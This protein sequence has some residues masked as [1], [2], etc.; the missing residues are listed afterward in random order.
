MLVFLPSIFCVA[1]G[2]SWAMTTYKQ[3]KCLCMHSKQDDSR[4]CQKYWTHAA[5]ASYNADTCESCFQTPC[6]CF[7][8]QD[9]QQ[10]IQIHFSNLTAKYLRVAAGGQGK[11]F[12][13]R[14]KLSRNK[15][16]KNMHREIQTYGHPNNCLWL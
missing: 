7:W 3:T 11:L 4:T 6:F 8:L 1:K 16:K 14:E 13:P 2:K 9:A 10:L 5:Q 12:L 15:K